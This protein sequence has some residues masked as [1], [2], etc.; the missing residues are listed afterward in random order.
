MAATDNERRMNEEASKEGLSLR[1][2]SW[3]W[4]FPARALFLARACS[5][6]P[7][8]WAVRALPYCAWPGV[9]SWVFA[10]SLAVTNAP[11]DCFVAFPLPHS[12]YDF[13]WPRS[14]LRLTHSHTPSPHIN[15]ETSRRQGRPSPFF[16]EQAQQQQQQQQHFFFARRPGP[17]TASKHG[18]G[19]RTRQGRRTRS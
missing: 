4:P 2:T 1:T 7:A 5:E 16:C 18:G 14:P 15:T 11:I 3:A 19:S 8:A 6:M 10:S 17:T 12:P 13:F 9:P